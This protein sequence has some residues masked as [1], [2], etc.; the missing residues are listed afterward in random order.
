M[1]TQ[2]METI[3][4]ASDHGGFELKKSVV[5]HLAAKGRDVRDLGPE[6]AE[7]TDYPL[8][9]AALCKSVLAT[10]G[11]LGILICGTG[12]GM[13]ITANRFAGI[14]AALCHNEFTARMTRAHNDANVLCLGERVLGKGLALDIVDVFVTSAFEGE[15]HKRR[16]DLIEEIAA[17]R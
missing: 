10:P 6:T 2:S 17:G 5:G 1:T 3:F 15:R 13:S 14:R 4:V 8:H 16:I 7:S 12:I 11:S 9:A